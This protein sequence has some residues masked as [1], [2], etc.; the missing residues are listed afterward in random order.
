MK[1]TQ[2]FE[3]AMSELENSVSRLESGSLSLDDSLLE[4]ENAVKLIKFCN[5]KITTA[6]QKVKILLE[7]NDGVISDT[8]FVNKCDET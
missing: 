8:D 4:F 7:N 2:T 5:D 6:E 3:E 1:K